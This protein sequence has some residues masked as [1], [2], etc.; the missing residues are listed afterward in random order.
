MFKTDCIFT[1]GFL[2]AV[3]KVNLC[4]KKSENELYF[5]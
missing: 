2:Y 5:I 4:I 3:F 1:I